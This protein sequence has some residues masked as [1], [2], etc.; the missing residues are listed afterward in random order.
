MQ[1][2]SYKPLGRLESHSSGKHA[3]QP[4]MYAIYVSQMLQL[5]TACSTAGS[6]KCMKVR[7]LTEKFLQLDVSL[8]LGEEWELL[9]GSLTFSGSLRN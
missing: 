9:Q 8:V 3:R 5:I 2:I 1:D 4:L 7:I 6:M